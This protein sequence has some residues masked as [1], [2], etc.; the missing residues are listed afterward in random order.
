MIVLHYSLN[1]LRA[2]DLRTVLEKNTNLVDIII[3]RTLKRN[4][5]ESVN[6]KHVNETHVKINT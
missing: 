6:V 5:H 2:I 4:V 1:P 3:S